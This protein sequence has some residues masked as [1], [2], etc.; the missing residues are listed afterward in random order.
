MGWPVNFIT[1][2]HAYKIMANNTHE[3]ENL[4]YEMEEL[5]QEVKEHF[6]DASF[7]EKLKYFNDCEDMLSNC[8]VIEREMVGSGHEMIF[9]HM[10]SSVRELVSMME[11]LVINEYRV[12]TPG[13]PRIG[14]SNQQLLLL[15]RHDFQLS[16]MAALLNCSV[17][18]VQR[19]LA[20]HGF[21]RRQRYKYTF[22]KYASQ[23]WLPNDW[24]YISISRANCSKE[25]DQGGTSQGRSSRFR[26][27]V[28]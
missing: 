20:E 10:V 25:K 6:K 7:D 1:V 28:N 23:Q 5:V 4:V 15:L 13:C 22:R 9:A 2:S 27:K 26:K 8:V 21:S 3:V 11:D 18:T 12:A 24:W 19:R 16:D 14:I 17:R